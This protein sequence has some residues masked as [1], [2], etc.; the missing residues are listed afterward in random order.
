MEGHGN[1]SAKV[2]DRI[3][4][5]EECVNNLIGKRGGQINFIRRKTN[6]VL[7][8]HTQHEGPVKPLFLFGLQSNVDAAKFRVYKA[9][10]RALFNIDISKYYEPPSGISPLLDCIRIPTECAN[11][12]TQK[13]ALDHIPKEANVQ[14]VFK[15]EHAEQDKPLFI[16]V[17]I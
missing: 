2:R 1:Q 16:F 17:S 7:D 9:L 5:P 13:S 8:L 6:A 14:F 12:I 15:G 10:R 4:I 3:G 11:I